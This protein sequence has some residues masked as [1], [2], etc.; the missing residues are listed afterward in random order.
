MATLVELAEAHTK[1][2]PHAVDHLQRLVGAWGLLADLSFSDLVLFAPETEANGRFVVIGQVRPSTGQTLHR[3]DLVGRV[4]DEV[5]RSLVAR[6]WRLGEITEGEIAVAAHGERARV[7]CIPV[8]HDREVVAVMTREAALTV[9][10]RPGELERVYVQVFER[11]ALM[12]ASGDFPFR[13]ED[14]DIE[15]APR[16]SDGLLLLDQGGRVDYASPNAVNALHRMGVDVSVQGLQLDEA[17]I[18]DAVVR[19]ALATGVPATEEL[20][21]RNGV[22]VLLRCI[23]FLERGEVNGGVVL[24]RDVTEIRR[25]DRLLL[26]KDAAIREV[27]HRVKNNLQT[28]SSLLRL[29]ARRVEKGPGRV[30]LTEAERRIRSIALVH[31]ILSQEPGEEVPFDQIVRPLVRMAEESAVGRQVAF[32]VTGRAGE[33]PAGVATPLAVV[34]T[35]LLQ[36]A[37]EHAFAERTSGTVEVDLENDGLELR[38]QVCDDGIG[39][40]TDFDIGT[41]SSLGLSI[42]RDLIGSQLQGTIDMRTDN[43]TQISVAIPLNR[44]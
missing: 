19:A 41:T 8:R 35:E 39:L 37:A 10:R 33:L 13:G 18:D 27:H 6:A 4:V 26:S 15:E 1:L 44:G 7:Q 9:G 3:E 12:V 31:E 23:P 32:K 2:G 22:I 36:N 28:I 16:V 21:R 11:F 25:R 40:P 17:S 42:V 14:A 38:V 29:Q 20:E 30:A 43:G 34:L 5:E 24:L